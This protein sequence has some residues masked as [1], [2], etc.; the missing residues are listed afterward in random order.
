MALW[1]Q[2]WTLTLGVDTD[3][4][5]RK[6]FRVFKRSARSAFMPW[7]I[8]D[9]MEVFRSRMDPEE[10]KRWDELRDEVVNGIGRYNVIFRED[11]PDDE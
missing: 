7:T 9:G 11:P 8:P 5:A 10:L 2:V 3:M 1:V 6:F 4:S